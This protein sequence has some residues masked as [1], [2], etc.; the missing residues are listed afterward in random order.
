MDQGDNGFPPLPDAIA[1]AIRNRVAVYQSAPAPSDLVTSKVATTYRPQS[2]YAPIIAD[3]AAK[4][5]LDPGMLQRFA[6]IESGFDP[7]NQTGSYKGL[8]QLSDQEFAKNGGTGNIYDPVANANAAAAKIAQESAGFQQ[9]YG[10]APTPTEIYMLHQQG[11]AGL[12][13]HLANPDA[14]AW[15]NM[16]STG[17][18]RQK[19]ARWAQ[20]AIW[21]N[22]PSNLRS[23]FGDVS[24]LTSKQFVDLWR[25]KVEGQ[26]AAPGAVIEAGSPAPSSPGYAGDAIARATPAAMPAGLLTSDVGAPQPTSNAMGALASISG[27]LGGSTPPAS[28]EPKLSDIIPK[29]LL[30]KD[31]LSKPALSKDLLPQIEYPVPPGLQAARAAALRGLLFK[32]VA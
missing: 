7:R 28:E 27:L 22:V 17:E 9:K 5:G 15:Q 26:G 30:S 29:D 14:P 16:L 24:N 23:Q 2:P 10:R 21:G 3:A 25:Q 31:L 32:G 1:D 18:G 4:Y 20:A 8:F 6:H 19:G 12:A 11:P 13:A